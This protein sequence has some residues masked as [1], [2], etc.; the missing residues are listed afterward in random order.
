MMPSILILTGELDVKNRSEALRSAISFSS[1]LT[2]NRPSCCGSAAIASSAGCGLV[3]FAVVGLIDDPQRAGGL[4]LEAVL[5]LALELD[6]QAQLVLRVRV[7]QAL[8]VGDHA[9]LVELE[10]R[11]VEGLHAEAVRARH[12]FL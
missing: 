6:A 11:L 7:A 2:L 12:D 8:L 9:A 3:D 10:Q 1:G 4:G 5:A